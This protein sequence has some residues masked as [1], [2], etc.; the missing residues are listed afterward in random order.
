MH[1][2][3]LIQSHYSSVSLSAGRL[4]T[5]SHYTLLQQLGILEKFTMEKRSFLPKKMM[6]KQK[7]EG[8]FPIW[9][10][11]SGREGGKKNPL[12]LIFFMTRMVSHHSSLLSI[13]LP[14]PQRGHESFR[15]SAHTAE[16]RPPNKVDSPKKIARKKKRVI[17]S[18]VGVKFLQKYLHAKGQPKNS[19][20][21]SGY[22]IFC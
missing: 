18:H 7:R 1:Y 11:Y 22:C 21:F 6:A 8:S 12:F 9:H 20:H 4:V 14:H 10:K 19:F 17:F 15:V 13:S 3:C 5:F 2:V 16:R